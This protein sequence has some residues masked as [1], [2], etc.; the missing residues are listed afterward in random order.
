MRKNKIPR[1]W[2][3]PLFDHHLKWNASKKDLESLEEETSIVGYIGFLCMISLFIYYW[4][5]D[6]GKP[7]F[8]DIVID[9]EKKNTTNSDKLI[10]E[11]QNKLDILPNNC[12]DFMADLFLYG[13][14]SLSIGTAFAMFLNFILKNIFTHKIK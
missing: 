3:V 12:V 6:Y 11:L 5:V 2:N 9:I 7:G 13:F 1:L 10:I 14:L 4:I 8:T